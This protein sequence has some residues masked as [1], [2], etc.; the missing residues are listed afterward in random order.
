VVKKLKGTGPG[1]RMP[2]N[3]EPLSDATIAMFEKWIEEGAKFDAPDP[4]QPIF[5]VAAIAKA[6]GQTHDEL[7]ADRAALADTNW[8][9]GMPGVN[10]SRTETPTF[11][12]LGD[13]GEGVLAE[14]VQKAESVVPK[15]ALIFKTP[16]D[17]PMVKGKMSLFVFRE[18][19]DYGEFGK[20]VEKRELPPT[21]RGHARYT[22]VDAYGAALLPR[23]DAGYSLETLIAQELGAVY[24][25]SQGRGVP[26][27]FSEGSGRVIAD[28][29]AT[30]DDARVAQW[31]N[32]LPRII[33]SLAAPDDFLTGKL[34]PEDADICAFSFVK[35]LMADASKYQNVLNS[36]RKGDDF[37]KAFSASFGGSPSQAT[38]AWVRKPPKASK[39]AAKKAD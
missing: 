1:A 5:E 22:I 33:G 12:V 31:D 23:A 36:L 9:L 10:A 15:V 8:R 35:F 25:A 7:S 2:L 38:A 29:L 16:P 20:M 11:L 37:T 4:K 13:V 19:Y 30:A 32:E 34:P 26:H 21:W 27:W 24:V 3:G 39:K 14:V 18:R 17:Q 28:R 6:Q